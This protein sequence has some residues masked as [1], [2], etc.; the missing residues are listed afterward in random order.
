[1]VREGVGLGEEQQEVVVAEGVVVEVAEVEE[2]VVE[3]LV[4]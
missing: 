2:G 4:T 3:I 1:M